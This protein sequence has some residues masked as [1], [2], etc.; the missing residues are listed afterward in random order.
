MDGQTSS[1]R[2][3]SSVGLGVL[4]LALAALCGTLACQ[5][6]TGHPA[7][8]LGQSDMGAFS[9]DDLHEALDDFEDF[10]ISTVKRT[11]GD[12]DA[13]AADSQ[14]RRNTLL[15]RV[16]MIP[17][18]RTALKQ[19]DQLRAF[20]DAWSLSVRQTQFLEDGE[21]KTLFGPHQPIAID[22]A[23]QIESDIERVGRLFLSDDRLVQTRVE[24]RAFASDHP[25]R[26]TFVGAYLR[27][28]TAKP[29]GPDPFASILAIPLVPFRAFEGIDRG[30]QAIQNFTEVA[31]RFVDV[32]EELPESTRWQLELILL[33]LKDNQVVRETMTNL[34]QLNANAAAMVATAQQLPA[35][36]RQ[37][38]AALLEEIDSRQASLQETLRQA[39]RTAAVV[40]HALA[41]VDV[42]AESIDRTAQ[43][44][45]KAGQ[46][47]VGTSHAVGE[48]VH[49]I[50]AL[51]ADRK[52]APR[53][54]TS[55]PFDI[56]DYRQTADSLTNAA[57]ELRQLTT[58]IQLILDSQQLPD[59]IE[60][61]DTR[62]QAAVDQ[63]TKEAFGLTDH[64]AWRLIQIVALIFVLAA[65]YR[66][67][68]AR[69][70][71]PAKA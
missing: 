71:K 26:G 69:Q 22:A 43:S 3:R 36:L 2:T 5:Q 68:I 27:M 60:D 28:A 19:D 18:C 58:E 31:D 29:G 42:V 8:Q 34:Q 51:G 41:R 59:R 15:W 35:E 4:G 25:M 16:R 67:V 64:I 33:D 10:F 57:S 50:A 56:N 65:V 6:Q 23:K 7:R 11:A 13:A 24:V 37:E 39:E 62:I 47:W 32:V 12:I 70:K 61:L 17:A 46:A 14:M 21:G 48:T 63:A 55:R 38:A 45:E 44:V 49:G 52:A 53:P 9:L 66:L 40:E 1:S 30:A 54:E 20:L